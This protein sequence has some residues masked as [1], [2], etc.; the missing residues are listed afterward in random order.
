MFFGDEALGV[1]LPASVVLMVVE[2][3][4]SFKGDT[5]SG[6]G[7]PA[8]LESGFTIQVP[9]FIETGERVKVDTR[10]GKYIERA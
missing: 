6:G 7:K 10:S 9:F 4:P 5:A 1:D 2:T 8:K 3:G